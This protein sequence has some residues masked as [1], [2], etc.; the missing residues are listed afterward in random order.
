MFDV[1]S[2]TSLTGLE[3]WHKEA[4][5]MGAKDSIFYVVG[6]K[7]RFSNIRLKKNCFLNI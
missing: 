6:N 7:V 4:M 3:M 5:E 1:T 2:K